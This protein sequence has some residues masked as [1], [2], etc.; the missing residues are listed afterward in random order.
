MKGKSF[1]RRLANEEEMVVDI[2]F[3]IGDTSSSFAWL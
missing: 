3:S 1:I 2:E